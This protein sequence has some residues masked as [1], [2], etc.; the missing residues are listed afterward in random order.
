MN[1]GVKFFIFLIK[2]NDGYEQTTQRSL[3]KAKVEGDKLKT[4]SKLISF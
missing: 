1:L 3:N 4:M 2:R